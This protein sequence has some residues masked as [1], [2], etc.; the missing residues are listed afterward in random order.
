MATCAIE[1]Y[2]PQSFVLPLDDETGYIQSDESVCLDTN[3]ASANSP[4]LLI[5]CSEFDR[6]KWRY[7][8][9]NNWLVHHKTNLCLTLDKRGTFLSIRKCVPDYAR[10]QWIVLTHQWKS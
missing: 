10:Q 6:Q 3:S 5:T 2:S 1:I 4:V 9:E 8:S 7:D